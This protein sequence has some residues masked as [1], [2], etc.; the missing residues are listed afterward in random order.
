MRYFGRGLVETEN[1]FGVQGSPPTHPELLDWLAAEFMD[2]GW[3]MKHIHR[4]IVTS[5]TYR[6]SSAARH[7]TEARDPLNQLLAR[8]TRPR[9]EAEIVRDAALAVSGML[10][11]AIGGPSVY[12]PQPEGVYAFTQRQANWRVSQGADRYRRSLYTFFMRSAP[13]PLFTTFDA[14]NF[15]QTCT[16]RMRSNTPLQSL[17]LA[18]DPGQFELAQALGARV[19]SESCG[20]DRARLERAF[21]LALARRPDNQELDQLVDYLGR[22]R[23]ALMASPEDAKRIAGDIELTDAR[24]V[25]IAAWVLVA[26]VLM[27]LDEFIT[28]E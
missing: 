8:Q 22:A 23:G 4:L 18:N 3:S 1:D 2:R 9:V 5:A 6:Q 27:N 10:T 14:P 12:P 20:G 15:S 16:R 28:R 19:L 7:D 26:R 24:P 25:D 21:R 13:H 11:D 17:T